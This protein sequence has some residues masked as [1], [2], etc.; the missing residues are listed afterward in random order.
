MDSTTLNSTSHF[1]NFLDLNGVNIGSIQANGTSGIAYAVQGVADFGEYMTLASKLPN[2]GTIMCQGASG[3]APCTASDSARIV[4]VVSAHTGFLGGIPGDNKVIVG[5]IGQIPVK[6]ATGSA[7]ITPGDAIGVVNNGYG[8]KQTT[9]GYIVGI[10]VAGQQ[11][12]GTVL[13]KVNPGWHEDESGSR[14]AGE[15]VS[16]LLS[17][18]PALPLSSSFAS[19]SADL[20]TISGQLTVIGDA[21]LA[22]TTIGGNLQV[23]F[24]HFDDIKAEISSLTGLVTVNSN[25]NV[26]GDATISGQLS[27]GKGIVI[28]DKTTGEDYC[29]QIDNG[30]IIKT[31]GE[32]Q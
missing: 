21:Q 1:L 28:P 27:V 23:G 13:V 18:L 6:I 29:V 4:G 25:L 17:V 11:P 12:D 16:S 9:R 24:L 8:Q 26:A 32:C 5:M 3:V 22:N 19:L 2:E 20:A 15:Q 14:L 30:E 10:A 7:M 31:K